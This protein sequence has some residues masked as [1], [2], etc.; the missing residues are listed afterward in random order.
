VIGPIN[1][2]IEFDAIQPSIITYD[3]NKMQILCRT[4]QNVVSESWS[5]DGGRTWSKMAATALPNPSAGTDAVT[6]SDGR[7][8]IVYNHTKGGRGS[9]RLLN[10]ALS[11]DG[12]SWDTVLTLEN[13]KG[14]YSYPAVIQAS[15][16]SIHI[17]YTYD[18]QS[19]KHVV[20]DPVELK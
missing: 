3:N 9:R 8:L 18:R 20:L 10:V 15:D 4:R 14:E 2:G 16:G 6:L 11:G 17:T 12:K 19:V 13:Q 5:S 7:Q 1:D